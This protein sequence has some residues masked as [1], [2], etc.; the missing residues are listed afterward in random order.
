MQKTA[1]LIVNL[2]TPDSA[3]K[4]N[5][6]KFISEFL[7]DAR[8]IDIPLI[9]R[10]LLV[11]LIIVPFRA[12][13]S[14]KL[15]QKLWTDEGSP[16]LT[17]GKSLKCK[18][19]NIL[20]F[21]NE[22]F[23]AMRYGNPN[24]K[25]VLD[26]IQKEGFSKIIILPLFP[27]YASSTTGSIL[28][29]ALKII[30]K[31]NYIPKINLISEF[32]QNSQFINAWV[33]QIKKHNVSEFD[34]ILFSYHGLPV[35]HVEQTHK[36]KSCNSFNCKNEINKVNHSCY[37]AQCFETTRLIA[38]ELN[39]N[40]KDYTVCFQS[41]FGKKWLSPFTEDIVLEEAKKGSTKLLVI[42]PAFVA[43]C[44]E[45]IVEI[46]M[47]YQQIFTKVG[48]EKIQLVKSLNDDNLW[49]EAIKDIIFAKNA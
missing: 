42:P 44:L 18:L 48:G 46:G 24:L 32:Y 10:K 27:Q 47:D 37:R 34:H 6:R 20:D 25:K 31:W 9:L 17:Y 12:A 19:K 14:T 45:T 5:V 8:V 2:G 35:R 7:N 11:N 23:L 39:L 4:K 33:K 3:S 49:V 36:N 28:E 29:H 43:D 15:Y 40:E 38:K 13:K 16:I 41:R 26:E 22:V 30:K 1:V 21:D